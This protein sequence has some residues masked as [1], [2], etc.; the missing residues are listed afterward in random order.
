VPVS[1]IAGASGSMGVSLVSS[2]VGGQK[3]CCAAVA[4][5][6]S[7]VVAESRPA[8]VATLASTTASAV[9]ASCV[10]SRLA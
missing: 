1:A 10:S 8:D 7:T 3:N 9:A 2:F 5:G 4:C 6:R